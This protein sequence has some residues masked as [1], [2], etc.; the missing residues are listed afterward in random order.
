MTIEI[1]ELIALEKEVARLKNEFS[2]FFSKQ[3]ST[4]RTITIKEIAMLEGVSVSQ[5]RQGGAERYLL[6]RFGQSGYPTG[7][8]RWNVEEYLE[9]SQTDPAER[10]Q[11]YLESLRNKKSFR[12]RKAI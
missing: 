1:P 4:K 2:Y 7:T 5:L 3:T 10:Q 8:T 12:E 9:W 11:A 6:P